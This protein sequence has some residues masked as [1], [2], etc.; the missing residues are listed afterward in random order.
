MKNLVVCLLLFCCGW[1]YILTF[2][3]TLNCLK[4]ILKCHYYY[5]NHWVSYP[6]RKLRQRWFMFCLAAYLARFDDDLTSIQFFSW[7][8]SIVNLQ[9]MTSRRQVP[10]VSCL[11]CLH[12]RLSKNCSLCVHYELSARSDKE[13][14][15][16]EAG[17]LVG[18]SIKFGLIK[19][20]DFG[21]I[22]S[23]VHVFKRH[24]FRSS[25]YEVSFCSKTS[26]WEHVI[27]EPWEVNW[28][29][30]ILHL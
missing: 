9:P 8:L 15:L 2:N 11:R 20:F 3:H 5:H 16:S 29:I 17:L 1:L 10:P 22:V 25:R 13:V 27:L 6:F 23:S 30:F 28:T 19:F 24:S 7:C 21:L 4:R 12:W 18:G 14:Y 26:E